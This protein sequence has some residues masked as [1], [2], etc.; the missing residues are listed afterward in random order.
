MISR[1]TDDYQRMAQSGCQAVS[2]PA[3]WAGFDR[4][5]AEGFRDYFRHLVEIEP[6]RA[7]Q[8][9]I[10]HYCW[11]CINAKEA[12]NVRLSRE[13]IA[14]I[15]EYSERPNV[16]GIGEIGLNKNTRN[17]ATIFQEHVDL[18]MKTNELMLIHTPHLEDKYKGTRMI[19]DMLT[20]DRR[21]DPERVCIDHVEEHTVRLALDKGF[22]CG[23]TLYPT[24][25]CTPERAADIVEMVGTERILANSAGDWGKSNPLA[26]PEFI[27]EMKRRGHGEDIIRRI[28]Y[29]NPFTFFRQA[30]RW[31][32]SQVKTAEVLPSAT[33]KAVRVSP[34]GAAAAQP[35]R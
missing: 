17:E 24:T 19:I 3:F 30:R 13:V 9:N 8:F 11:L 7:A 33:V 16:L 25:K 1:V 31:Q 23:M 4:G 6:K 28:V 35:S 22:W 26:V 20:G 2:E 15:P 10:R 18:A 34:S 27:Q 29:D 5:S 12:E 21:V 14:L 32:E